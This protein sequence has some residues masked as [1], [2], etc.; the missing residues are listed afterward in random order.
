[1]KLKTIKIQRNDGTMTFL[2]I[3]KTSKLK[4]SILQC[5]ITN[6]CACSSSGFGAKITQPAGGQGGTQPAGGARGAAAPPGPVEPNKSSLWIE[7]FSLS[8]GLFSLNSVIL[9][10]V[11]CSCLSF[12]SPGNRLFHV[13]CKWYARRSQ[14]PY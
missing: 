13:M 8:K 4:S 7:D 11:T 10:V 2:I 3:W 12:S 1:M 9:I 6:F 14:I 5:K